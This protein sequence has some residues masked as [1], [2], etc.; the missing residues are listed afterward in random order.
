[1]KKFLITLLTTLTIISAQSQST[2]KLK[3]E[4]LN[5]IEQK[6]DELTSLSDKIW[7]A[8]EVAFRENKSAEYLIEYAEANGLIV[9]KGLAGM[10]TAFTAS[11]GQ[12]K[13]VIGIIG[14]F[15]ALPGLSQTSDSHRNVLIEG[16]AGHG[17]GHNLFGTASLG[18]AIAIK[19][20]IEKG[21][22]KGTVKFFGTPAEEKFFGKLWMIR[23]GVFDDVDICMDWHPADKTEANVQ[24]SLAL[25]DFMVEFSGQS[26]HASVDPWN[27]RSA[28]DALEL[29]TSGINAYR[30]HVKPSVRMHYHI[31]DAGQ[32][33]NVVPDYS[34][35]WVRVRDI[36][37]EGLQPVYDQVRRMAGG[38]AIMANVEH[39]V[40][41]ISGVHDLLP[42]RVGGAAMQKNLE[43]LGDIV[44][45]KKEIDFA[46]EMQRNNGKP[47]L[48]IDGVI[49][50][51]RETLK[52]PGGGST[53][54]GDVSYNVPVVSLNATTAPKG[55]P[56]HSWSVVASSGMSIGH[57]GMLHAAKALGMTMVDIFKDSKLREDI[58]KEFDE[59]IGEYEYDPYLD[60]GPPPIDYID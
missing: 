38:A 40:S 55:V 23:D 8:A 22:L 46:L 20:L 11:Y 59:K 50:P 7:E 25:V 37:K 30:E 33:V 10:P 12:E 5:S 31:Q 47:E 16:G 29:Y 58:K 6:A 1:M 36:T 21:D 9:E 39:K 3:K 53:D 52:S 56:W 24:P 49:R 28:N 48:G 4:L 18:A 17:C 54:S 44:Y 15:D 26:A 14:E 34:R 42:N 60:P 43:T 45:T 35:I 32:V 51:L 27:A 2:N 41:L 57:K 19:E 13:P